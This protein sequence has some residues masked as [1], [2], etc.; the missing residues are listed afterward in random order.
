MQR[1]P[2]FVSSVT[3]ADGSLLY[4]ASDTAQ[5]EFARDSADR[6][7]ASLK[8]K[9]DCNGVACVPEA[10]PWI[11]GYTPQ[12]AVTVYVEKVDA[13]VDADLPRVIWHE[14]LTELA[15]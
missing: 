13:V 15:R 2:H 7:T 5:P 3:A 1:K 12:L 10:S 8:E 4:M 9:P 14:F 11:V 6:I